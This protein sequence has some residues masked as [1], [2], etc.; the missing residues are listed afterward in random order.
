[1]AIVI[2]EIIVRTTVERGKTKEPAL[3]AEW[4]EYIRQTVEEQ[5]RAAGRKNRQKGES[6]EDEAGGL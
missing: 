5:L 6:A 1:M 3:S 4:R 2:K